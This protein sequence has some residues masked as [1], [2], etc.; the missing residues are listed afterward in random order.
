MARSRAIR[1]AVFA[2]LLLAALWLFGASGGSGMFS[3]DAGRGEGSGIRISAERINERVQIQRR[4]SLAIGAT[5]PKQILFGDL[6]VH[7]T[8]SVDAFLWSLPMLQGSGAHPPA[9]ACDFARFCSGLDFWSINDHA[10]DITPH[11]WQE[12]REMVRE[13]NAVAGD[14]VN[15]D[16]VTFLGWEWTQIGL[17]PETHYGHKNVVLLGT[18]DDETPTRP[19]AAARDLPGA[20]RSMGPLGMVGLSSLVLAQ[21]PGSMKDGFET[22]RVSY[23]RGKA[24]ECAKGV[25]VKDLPSDCYED[26]ATPSSLFEKLDQWGHDSMVIPHGTTWGFY[27]PAG[28]S[29]DK[30]LV[31]KMH[32]SERQKLFEIFSG[33]GN[34]EQYRDWRAVDRTRDG[35]PFCPP[36]S[37]GYLP[38]CWRAGQII[39]E[40]CRAAGE[41]EAECET[42][43]AEAR[44]L[45]LAA[46]QA[47]PHVVPG[48]LPED[49]L[50]SGQCSDCF[51][52]AF[53][54]RPGNAGQRALAISNFDDPSHPRRF[55]FGFMASSDNHSARPGTGY[56]EYARL[57]MTE[58]RGFSSESHQY[59]LMVPPRESEPRALPYDGHPMRP[60]L[61]V[62]EAERQASYFV[63]GGLIAAHSEG[64]DRDSI[65]RAMNS[66]EVYGTSGDRI[67]LWFDLLNPTSQSA[68]TLPMGSQTE[69]ATTPRFRVRAIGAFEQKPGCPS[70]SLEALAGERL[71]KLCRGECYYPS[72]TRRPIRTIEVVRIRPQ[73][74]PGEE[75]AP[76]IED[77]WMRFDCTGDPHGCSV[78]FEDDEYVQT[79]RD[80]VYYVRALQDTTPTVNA[81]PLR[82]ERDAYGRC[83]EANPCFASYRG[84]AN[85][86]C[87]A[88]AQQ[89]AW[90]SPIFV[91]QPR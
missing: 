53:N 39:G 2:A 69:L 21:P 83:I 26:A 79:G 24:P 36:P 35:E 91:D 41:S 89:R 42:R 28:A 74:R 57:E 31:G 43:A 66:R 5:S 30:Q 15:P 90:S 51:L 27:T 16:I 6:H 61:F 71:E 78:E 63:T 25:H 70:D 45:F 75:I 12:T 19:I 60:P 59:P 81:D 18:Q 47:G 4:A 68:T 77:P 86:D 62:W 80:A 23:E 52:P 32:D 34:S 64:R 87:L 44:A 50:D 7:T 10:E 67:L 40:R 38:S 58:A 85:D 55:R 20:Q 29:I 46:G 54:Y 88:P 8:F 22:V 48:A 37:D 65:W 72:D 14:P 17:T 13:C 1:I 3:H 11:R 49:W 84:D 73:I 76:L 33:H 82:C 9:D 56:K